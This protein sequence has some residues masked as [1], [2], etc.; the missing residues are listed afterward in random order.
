MSRDEHR[1]ANVLNFSDLRNCRQEKP[2]NTLA[3]YA[4]DKCDDAFSRSDW[5]RFGYWFEVY[6][7]ERQRIKWKAQ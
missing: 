1:A 6:R 4:L 7:R 2:R 5:E 3:H